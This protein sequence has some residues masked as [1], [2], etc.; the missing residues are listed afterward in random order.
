MCVDID[1]EIEVGDGYVE[2]CSDLLLEL[3][4]MCSVFLC[5][6]VVWMSVVVLVVM[7]SWLV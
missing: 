4:C 7:G 2:E 3:V 1:V 5:V 6:L